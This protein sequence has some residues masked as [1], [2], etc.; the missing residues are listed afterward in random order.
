MIKADK[1]FDIKF[2]DGSRLSTIGRCEAKFLFSNLYGFRYPDA[3]M[4]PLDYGTVM[5]RVHPYMFSGN[6]TKAIE[7]F[8]DLWKLY[9][10]GEEDQKRNT[11]LTIARIMNFVQNHTPE[12]CPYD[13]VHFPFSTPT[14]L[15][16]EN[17]V[18][19]LIDIGAIYPFCGRIDMI[20]YHKLLKSTFAYDFKTSAEISPRYFEGFWH[21]NQAVGYTIATE[22]LSG[23]KVEGII[24]EAMRISKSNFENQIGFVYV[25]ETNKRT[26]IEEAKL[27]CARVEAANESKVWR[28]CTS[29]CSS[30]SAF[31]FPSRVCEYKLLCDSPD[32]RTAARFYERKKPFDPLDLDEKG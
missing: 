20:V 30:Y 2:M 24:Y 10:Y 1:R 4:I 6:T 29:L 21:S 11:A 5:H 23:K 14:K 17:E 27:T 18:P 22:Q 31:G 15:I 25:S 16:S 7:T 32:W 19:F 8:N 13:I 26:F 28:Q 12:N 9:D 3:P